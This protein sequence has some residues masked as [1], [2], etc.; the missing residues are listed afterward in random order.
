MIVMFLTVRPPEL[1]VLHDSGRGVTTSTSFTA[2]DES[3]T[4]VEI[5][6][7]N[8]PAAFRRPENRAGFAT[9]LDRFGEY[10]ASL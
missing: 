10:V 2:V 4:Q 7:A 9:S 1:L 6:Q 5:R 3:H 8:V